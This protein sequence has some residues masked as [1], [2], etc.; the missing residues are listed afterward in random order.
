MMKNLSSEAIYSELANAVLSFDAD[1]VLETT[2]K[3]LDLGL[4]P[5]D[6]IENGL[7]KGL[8][9][10]GEKFEKC[11][12]WLMQTNATNLAGICLTQIV[13][14]GVGVSYGDKYLSLWTCERAYPRLAAQSRRCIV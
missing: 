3:A 2:K 8:K 4:S 11:E 7:G 13:N 1:K 5:G 10:V 6:I 14:P 9:M 12:I